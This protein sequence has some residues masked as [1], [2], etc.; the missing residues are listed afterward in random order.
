VSI[1]Y[2]WVNGS[3]L[4]YRLIR[5]YYGGPSALDSPR[6]R[7]NDELRYSLRSLEEMMPW[8]KGKIYFVTPGHYPHWLN[9]SHPRVVL[10]NQDDL[11]PDDGKD[12]VV[13]PTFSSN[14]VELY[15]CNIPGL[16]DI[17]IHMNDDYILGKKASP[18]DY[19][20][21]DGG[22]R[23]FF[24]KNRILGGIRDTPDPA[25]TWVSS[26][27]TTHALLQ[28]AYGEDYPRYFVKHAPFVYHKRAFE[29]LHEKWPKDIART[30]THKFRHATDILTPFLHHYYV[31]H[32]GSVCCNMKYEIAP[33]G[34]MLAEAQLYY[35]TDIENLF[36]SAR[37]HRPRFMAINDGYKAINQRARIKT[38][39]QELY[40]NPSSFEL[41]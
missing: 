4:D 18:W 37:Q 22:T 32:E 33:P 28:R 9:R 14:V 6:D 12:D 8:H 10:V 40:P 23:F 39:L 36:E 31:V 41:Y 27:Y 35:V 25:R 29:K 38:F 15:L 13:L 21:A 20:T 7:D 34:E 17:F 30:M 19:F 3:E 2:T 16:T 1:V 26:V 24:E 11:I 5:E